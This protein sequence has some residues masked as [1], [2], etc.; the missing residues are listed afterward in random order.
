MHILTGLITPDSGTIL[1]KGQEAVLKTPEDALKRKIGMVHQSPGIIK[2]FTIFENIIA[3]CGFIR[4]LK[5]DLSGYRKKIEGVKEKYSISINIDSWPV[6]P[7]QK[8]YTILLS[9]LFKGTDIIV[10]DE[11]TTSFTDLKSEEFFQILKN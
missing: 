1:Y 2:G 7:E 5:T 9:L 6:T 10:F 11:P 8:Q 3:G 4:G